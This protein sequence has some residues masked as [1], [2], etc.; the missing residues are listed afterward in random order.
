MI[1]QQRAGGVRGPNNGK[2]K[3]VAGV[4]QT[5]VLP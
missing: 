5:S 4:A 2:L 3:R 1:V